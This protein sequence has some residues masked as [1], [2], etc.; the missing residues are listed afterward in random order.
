MQIIALITIG[1]AVYGAFHL[2]Q[3]LKS[4]FS[5]ATA[6]HLSTAAAAALATV[7]V[8]LTSGRSEAQTTTPAL[9]LDIDLTPLFTSINQN[10][11]TFFGIFAVVGG[12]S[13]AIV[14]ARY[15]INAVKGAFEGKDV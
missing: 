10:L 11:P 15:L 8:A 5:L 2:F 13:I 1:L 14:L 3:E 4:R 12:L 6:K 7:A 9:Q